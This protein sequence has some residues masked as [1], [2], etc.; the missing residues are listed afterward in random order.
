MVNPE[1]TRQHR[2]NSGH[3]L[4]AIVTLLTVRL[5]GGDS[6]L[7]E[8]LRQFASCSHWPLSCSTLLATLREDLTPSATPWLDIIEGPYAQFVKVGTVGGHTA[9][10]CGSVPWAGLAFV[11][12]VVVIAERASG[13]FVAWYPSFHL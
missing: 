10:T 13:N 9:E 12:F 4:V 11:R 2:D 5:H 7:I 3:N 1:S 6:T 8:I